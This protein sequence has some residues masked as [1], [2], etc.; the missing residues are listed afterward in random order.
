[1]NQRKPRPIPGEQAALKVL[2]LAV[3]NLE[4]FRGRNAGISEQPN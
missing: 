4:E 3:R 1:M 2:F